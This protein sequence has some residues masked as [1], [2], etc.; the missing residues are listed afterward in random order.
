MDRDRGIDRTSGGRREGHLAGAH[1]ADVRNVHGA[2]EGRCTEG[3]WCVQ[4]AYYVRLR[5]NAQIEDHLDSLEW[6]PYLWGARSNQGANQLTCACWAGSGSAAGV[7]P[8][9]QRNDLASGYGNR[10]GIGCV[11]RGK[12]G[13]LQGDGRRDI[14]AENSKQRANDKWF[15]NRVDSRL[16]CDAKGGLRDLPERPSEGDGQGACTQCLTGHE[17]ETRLECGDTGAVAALC[18]PGACPFTH[19]EGS[20]L[21]RG[22]EGGVI[23]GVRV[24]CHLQGSRHLCSGDLQYPRASAAKHIRIEAGHVQV[25]HDLDGN[26]DGDLAGGQDDGPGLHQLGEIR[27]GLDGHR[28]TEVTQHGNVGGEPVGL[29]SHPADGHDGSHGPNV[30]TRGDEVHVDG[31]HA[32]AVESRGD[33][34]GEANAG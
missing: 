15:G 33:V 5:D 31:A 17:E 30:G 3:E 7:T 25:I 19:Q 27:V 10:W 16:H 20:S 24:V 28:G 18:Y 12:D 14:S 1:H 13:V 2:D 9:R 8:P 32:G 26:P 6:I 4:Q 29:V 21:V 34:A 23:N 11:V 22:A